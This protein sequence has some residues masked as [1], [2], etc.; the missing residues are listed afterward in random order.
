MCGGAA[1]HVLF[2]VGFHGE[3]PGSGESKG[4]RAATTVLTD[5]TS[6]VAFGIHHG[7]NLAESSKKCHR[8]GYSTKPPHV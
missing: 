6:E 5:N 7:Q 2:H 8:M 4:E 3:A 1:H